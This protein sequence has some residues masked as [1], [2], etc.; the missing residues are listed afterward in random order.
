VAIKIEVGQWY[1]SNIGLNVKC[2]YIDKT[3]R[4]DKYVLAFP[5]GSVGHHTAEAVE[6][7]LPDCTGFDWKPP[8][9]PE[10]PAGWR[11]LGDDEQIQVGDHFWNRRTPGIPNR[12]YGAGGT[13][14]EIKHEFD[15][16][17]WG[18]IRKVPTYRP[19]ANAAEFAPHRDRWIQ[20]SSKH[21]TVNTIPSGC[22]RVTSYNDHHV[23]TCD[24]HPESY[25]TMFK[26]GKKFD[27][28]TPFGVLDE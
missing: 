7:H 20:R 21:D 16:I 15:D 27:D 1:R 23:W 22:F 8:Q 26:D 12:A 18:I 17:A 9:R 2:I 11:W 10:P 5:D 4:S 3:K 14:G 25:E 28:G 24:G 19:F 6:E 13:W